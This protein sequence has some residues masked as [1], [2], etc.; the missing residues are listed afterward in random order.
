MALKVVF[1]AVGNILPLRNDTDAGR[2]VF[3]DLRHEQ[4]I[5]GAAEDDGIDFRV[6]TH[7]LIYALL[8]EIVGT[9]RIGLI[10]F[11]KGHPER[12]GDTRVTSGSGYFVTCCY[13][14]PTFIV[15]SKTSMAI[16]D[17]R[18]PLDYHFP[19]VIITSRGA[20]VRQWGNKFLGLSMVFNFTNIGHEESLTVHNIKWRVRTF[21]GLRL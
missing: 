21:F 13:G 2:E 7:N 1:Q 8:H 12:T 11:H 20:V 16:G 3:Q 19:E 4:R 18:V 5:V 6:E 9:R 17:D 14:T 10:V 15:Y